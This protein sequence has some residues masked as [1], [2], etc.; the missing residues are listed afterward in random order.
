MLENILKSRL[1]RGEG[2]SSYSIFE[3]K[4]TDIEWYFEVA[5]ICG[6]GFTPYLIHIYV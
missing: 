6:E 1:Y 2:Y 3:S 5:F 4:D